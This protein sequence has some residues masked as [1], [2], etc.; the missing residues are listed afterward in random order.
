MPR[1]PDWLRIGAE[2]VCLTDPLA[3]PLFV[4]TINRDGTVQISAGGEVKLCWIT[5]D[6]LA[7]DRKNYHPMSDGHWKREWMAARDL[8]TAR[9]RIAQE[10]ARITDL[11]AK[12]DSP[13]ITADQRR[14]VVEAAQQYF[15]MWK[16]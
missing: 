10:Q 3:Q 1:H 12:A 15:D 14:Q 5:P 9:Q 8:A 2:V 11:L 6:F 13:V 7:D 4:N 16:A